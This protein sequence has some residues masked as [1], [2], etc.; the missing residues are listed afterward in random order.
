MVG[1]VAQGI[2]SDGDQVEPR[3]PM[4]VQRGLGIP[5]DVGDAGVRDGIGA[6]TGQHAEGGP[7][8]V[9]PRAAYAGVLTAIGCHHCSH[10]I[11]LVVR[12]LV[13]GKIS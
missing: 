7:G 6:L 4:G 11:V 13:A 12:A 2:E 9:G 3:R 10:L 8:D 5:G 1:H